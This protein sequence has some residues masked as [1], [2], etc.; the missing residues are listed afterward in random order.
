MHLQ[1]AANSLLFLVSKTIHLTWIVFWTLFDVLIEIIVV[2]NNQ[3]F[4]SVA[5]YCPVI[6]LSFDSDDRLRGNFGD[7]EGSAK[8]KTGA[9][10]SAGS[11]T[12]GHRWDDDNWSL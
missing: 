6:Q 10:Y 8:Y 3:R 11:L 4:H 9:N 12:S 2:R 7:E 1:H 5:Q